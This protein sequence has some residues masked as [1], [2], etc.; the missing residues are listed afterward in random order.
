MLSFY[1]KEVDLDT[2][3]TTQEYRLS[4]R[5]PIGKR[6]QLSY[7]DCLTF[8]TVSNITNAIFFYLTKYFSRYSVYPAELS[9]QGKLITLNKDKI[10]LIFMQLNKIIETNLVNINC[11]RKLR[12]LVDVIAHPSRNIYTVV[13]DEQYFKGFIS[14]R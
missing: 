5:F 1:R 9:L 4:R 8:R 6:H 7:L 14:F 10:I 11:N 12:N 13:G 2:P 3:E